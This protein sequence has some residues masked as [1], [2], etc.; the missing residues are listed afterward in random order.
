MT[1]ENRAPGTFRVADGTAVW[2]ADA[3]AEW[4]PLAYDELVATA[5]RYQAVISYEEL[6]EH[7]QETSGV[8]TRNPLANWIGKLLEAIAVLAKA[9]GDP[10][11]ISLCVR[12][13]G[14][15]GSAYGRILK[16]TDDEVTG[17]VE[18]QAAAHR[19]VCYQKYAD[20]LPAGGGQ[21]AP[22]KTRTRAPAAP[23]TPRAPRA[24]KA[25]KAVAAPEPVRPICPV[26]FTELPMSGICGQCDF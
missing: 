10:P 11:L 2:F 23:R 19:L 13:D 7:V 16:A 5:G 15:V 3:L 8:R 9:Q 18:R 22:T 21:V 20:D 1:D 6:S 4:I 26:H 14:T 12:E 24:V 25:P 17:N